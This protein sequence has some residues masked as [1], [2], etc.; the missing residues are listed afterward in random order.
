MSLMRVIAMLD[1][2][3]VAQ[4]EGRDG[5]GRDRQGR[6]KVPAQRRGLCGEAFASR[7]SSATAPSAL[8]GA[9]PVSVSRTA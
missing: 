6:W 7:R 9:F 8:G 5:T 4:I 3:A 1:G 2:L